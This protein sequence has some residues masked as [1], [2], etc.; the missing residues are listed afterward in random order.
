MELPP[1]RVAGVASF[2]TMYYKE[3]VG[4]HHFQVC[5]TLSCA[6]RGA[7]RHHRLH[8]EAPRHPRRRDHRRQE[9]HPERGRVPRLVRHRAD[10]AADDDYVENLTEESTLAWSTELAKG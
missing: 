10:D 6:L 9:V 7:D 8:R 1:A 4:K 2:Y 3:P 5:R